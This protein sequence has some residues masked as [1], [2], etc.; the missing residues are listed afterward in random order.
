VKT[1]LEA[2]DWPRACE[3][4][5]AHAESGLGRELARRLQPF[6]SLDSLR[7]AVEAVREAAALL[8]LPGGAAPAFT[9]I[10]D[11]SP[12]LAAAHQRA[13]GLEGKELAAVLK[14]VKAGEFVRLRLAG[15]RDSARLRARGLAL[16]DLSAVVRSL[17]S[18]VDAAGE[19]LDEALPELAELRRSIR[20]SERRVRE[21][22]LD[23]GARE[24][25]RTL[26]RDGPPVLRDGRFMLAVKA[27]ARGRVPGILH[28][29]SASGETVFVEPSELIE[30]QNRL[31][32]VR[33]KERR[34]VDRLLLDRTRELLRSEAAIHESQRLLASLDALFARARF[35]RAL[36]AASVEVHE[37][38]PLVLA[39]AFHPLLLHAALAPGGGGRDSVVPFDLELGGRFDALVISGPNTGGKTATLKAV[40]LL[41]AL[42]L[43]AVPI[44]VAGPGGPDRPDGIGSR[45]PWFD[46]VHADVGDEQDL[47][48]S[49]STFSGHLRRIADLLSRATAK[50]LV[51]LDELG[52][53]TEPKEGEALGRALLLALL[54]RGC[55][56]VA[57]THLSGL[58]DL[59]FQVPRIE[60]ASLEFD[61]ETLQPLFRLTMGLPGESSALKIARRLG[62]PA[63]IVEEAERSLASG[64]DREVGAAR[65][66]A[67]RARRAAL[68]HLESAEEA[69]RRADAERDELVKRARALEEKAALLE[70][71]KE[72]EI[73]RALA[74]AQVRGREKLATLG[75]VPASLAPAVDELRRFLDS[76]TERTSLGERRLAYLA[77]LKK[78]DSV[79]L[80]R[81]KEQCVVR[82]VD[83]AKRQLVVLYKG[84]PVELSFDEV[85]L[86]DDFV[87]GA[88]PA[89]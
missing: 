4:V 41:V 89:R 34:V 69:R 38:G 59:G 11:L 48:Q 44:P 82:K 83:A 47:A 87:G 31:A 14:S 36:G 30:P 2:L 67:S 88:G 66:Q 13:A 7:E 52:T 84:M 73:V 40:G 79:F 8:E 15:R 3:L 71:E 21:L 57:T 1:S 26:L 80:P 42:A 81:F 46:E 77:R 23:V 24:Q 85:R 19:I 20:D 74:A 39:R 54:E 43:A 35:G 63:P 12:L 16:P 72:Q 32:D 22:A 18:T 86:P 53:G 9:A 17:E 65:E 68:H 28:D 76:M 50:S 10:A 27:D 6:R 51:L 49:L 45:V 56:V 70:S 64:G 78:G 62:I 75:T 58:K 55:K 29:R 33:A 5:A 61:G 25:W 37:G 60:N